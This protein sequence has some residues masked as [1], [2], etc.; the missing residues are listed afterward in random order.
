MV[1]YQFSTI[2]EWLA[3]NI[4]NRVVFLNSPENF[5]DPTENNFS[6]KNMDECDGGNEFKRKFLKTIKDDLSESYKLNE[7]EKSKILGVPLSSRYKDKF[8]EEY[9][10]NKFADKLLDGLGG[11]SI[12]TFCHRSVKEAQEA[13]RISSFSK[14]QSNPLMWGHYADGMRGVCIEYDIDEKDL[15]KV[16]YEEC[17]S[18]DVLR[19]L[20]RET[21]DEVKKTFL[22]KNPYWEY[23]KEYRMIRVGESYYPLEK[24]RL[25]KIYFGYKC[26]E[27]KADFIKNLAILSHGDDVRFYITRNL[28]SSQYMV[29]IPVGS[30][31][32]KERIASTK[33]KANEH[34][35]F[36]DDERLKLICQSEFGKN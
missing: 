3:Q 32:L 14:N 5:N 9:F 11:E 28:V 13:F 12:D 8:D 19:V 23:E 16:E 17:Y 18:V 7:V 24:G 33:N 2:S 1:V 21:E 25:K 34:E 31:E 6:L 36:V 22:R 15:N 35:T 30:D 26:H 4:H 20:A 29:N 27:D 10:V